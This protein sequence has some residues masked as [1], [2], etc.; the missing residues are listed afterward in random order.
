MSQPSGSRI[1]TQERAVR[2]RAALVEAARGEVSARG[3]AATTARS[4]A[5]AAGVATGSFYQYFAD[6]DAILRELGAV[7][8]GHVAT[9][10]VGLLEVSNGTEHT[11][12]PEVLRGV[13]TAVMAFHQ[14]DPGLHAVLTE[15]RGLD[16]EL[17]ALTTRAEHALIARVASLLTR[18]GH[19]GDA[20]ATAY[21][22]HSM[23]EG[24]VHAHVLGHAML[25]DARFREALVDAVLRVALPSTMGS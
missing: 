6:K 18:W 15:R 1:P 22:I 12:V 23:V 2:T 14:E 4:I 11:D 7:R 10:I 16:P 3:Y 21:I 20:D 25:D 9:D 19:P 5:E 8:L 17:D 13:V 24:S